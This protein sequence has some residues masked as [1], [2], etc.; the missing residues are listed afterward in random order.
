MNAQ[1]F[2]Q[3]SLEALQDAQSLAIEHQNMQIEQDH[4]LYALVSQEGGLIG[5]LLT[6]MNINTHIFKSRLQQ[7]IEGIP[8]VT[9]PGREV[10]KIYISNEVDKVLVMLKARLTE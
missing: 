10:G 5:E 2:T 7:I 3:K 1:K 4:L 8:R 6:K 9:G